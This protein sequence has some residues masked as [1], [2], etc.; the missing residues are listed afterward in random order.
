MVHSFHIFSAFLIIAPHLLVPEFDLYVCDFSP[1]L[2]GISVS[3]EMATCTALTAIELACQM[4]KIKV[5]S[6]KQI[7]KFYVVKNKLNIF[8]YH[9][10]SLRRKDKQLV[11]ATEKVL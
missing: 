4:D 10:V 5:S 1:T 9:Q 3:A 11:A 8:K 6:R 2:H 7:F